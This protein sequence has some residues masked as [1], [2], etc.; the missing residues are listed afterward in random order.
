MLF[1]LVFCFTASSII[2]LRAGRTINAP[3]N[4]PVCPSLVSTT[5]YLG[6]STTDFCGRCPNRPT[7]SLLLLNVSGAIVSAQHVEPSTLTAA[8]AA[9][10]ALPFLADTKR[11]RVTATVDYFEP[12]TPTIPATSPTSTLREQDQFISTATAHVTIDALSSAT[13]ASTAAPTCTTR[14][15]QFSPPRPQSISSTNLHGLL[16]PHRRPYTI[17]RRP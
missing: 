11:P 14:K 9:M 16:H 4:P 5:Y 12:P 7:L 15:T 3:N 1:P 17:Y 2:R 13:A 6:P 8:A 10:A